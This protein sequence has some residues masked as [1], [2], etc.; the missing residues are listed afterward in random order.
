ME[1]LVHHP[2]K[3]PNRQVDY[4][5]L[6]VSIP[7]MVLRTTGHG[8]NNFTLESLIDELAHHAG[9]DPYHYRRR[10]LTDNPVVLG[11]IDRAAELAGW[12]KTPAGRFQGMSFA[13]CF[14][15]YLCQ[16]VEL[17][18]EGGA[19]KLHRVVSVCD[20][21]RVLDR[22]NATSNIEGGVVWGLSAALYSSISFEGGRTRESNFDRFSVV[23]LPDTPELVTDFLEKRGP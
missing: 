8:P 9:I 12:G 2:Y 14:G 4:N 23:T 6:E 10:L 13:D 3:I 18:M 7:T 19:I 16:V 17:S 1:G 5:M 22:V 21:G 15:A 11:V 20:P